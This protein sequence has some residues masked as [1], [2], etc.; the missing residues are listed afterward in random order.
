[1]FKRASV[2]ARPGEQIDVL[3][4]RFKKEVQKEG[5]LL[6]M[7]EKEV[8][9]SKSKKKYQKRKNI[10]F[11]RKKAIKKKE[12]FNSLPKAKREKILKNRNMEI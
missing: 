12:L 7:A 5:I 9:I 10:E 3:I 1:M 6:K 2:I 4:A 8:Y 11:L